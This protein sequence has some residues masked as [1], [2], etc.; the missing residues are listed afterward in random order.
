MKYNHRHAY[1]F[2]WNNK[3][4]KLQIWIFSMLAMITSEQCLTLKILVLVLSSLDK[5]NTATSK[6]KKKKK[7]IQW[8]VVI[9]LWRLCHFY[10][11]RLISLYGLSLQQFK[12][13][14]NSSNWA[15]EIVITINI[16]SFCLTATTT[17]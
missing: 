5:R 8:D 9:K 11:L 4:R 16:L 13:Q 10:N 7:K 6:K 3:N 17:S 1:S 15:S 2:K 12:F 14:V